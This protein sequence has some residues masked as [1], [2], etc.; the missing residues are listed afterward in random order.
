MGL[1]LPNR[2]LGHDISSCEYVGKWQS[3]WKLK[4]EYFGRVRNDNRG[5]GDTFVSWY[6]FALSQIAPFVRHDVNKL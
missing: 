2:A 4:L 5:E 1:L 3:P 6:C